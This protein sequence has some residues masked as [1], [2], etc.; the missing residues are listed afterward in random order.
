MTG[1][2]LDFNTAQRQGEARTGSIN[3]DDIRERLHANPRSF[4][5]WLYSGRAYFTKHEARIGN[6]IGE[7]GNSLSIDL[8]TGLWH[9]H[10]TSEGGDLISLYRAWRGYAGDSNFVLSLKEIA[11]DYLGDPVELER[12]TWKPTV[13]AQLAESKAKLGTKPREENVLLGAPVATYTY[14]DT[15]GNVIASVVRFEP[16]GTRASKTFRPWCFKTVDGQPKWSPGAP[17]LRPLYRLPEIAISPTVVLCEGEGCAD[18]LAAIGFPATS[19]MQGAHA[20]IDKTDWSPLAGKT[21]IIWPDN[22][23][24]GFAYAKSVSER[25]LSLGCTVLGITPPADA[26]AKWDAADA[27]AESFDVHAIIAGASPVNAQPRPKIRTF[28]FAALATEEFVEEPDYLGPDFVGPGTFMLIAGPPKAQKSWLVQDINIALATG[29][30]CLGGMMAAPVPLRVFYLQAEMNEKL[31]RRRA[32]APLQWLADDDLALLSTNLIVSDRFRMILDDN[33]V[34]ATIDL[35]RSTFPGAPPDVLTFDPLINLFDQENESDNAQMMKF[36]QL[37]IEAVRDAIN[38][39]AAVIMVHHATKKSADEIRKDPF[40]IIRG[41]GALRGHYDT[42]IVIFKKSEDTEEREVHFDLRAAE[43]PKS[44]TVQLINGAFKHLGTVGSESQNSW[45]PEGIQERILQAIDKAWHQK[46]PWSLS[47][48]TKREGR[49]APKLIQKQFNV[50]PKIA[51]K[52]IEHWLEERV[53][54]VETFNRNTKA[55]GLKRVAEVAEVDEK[56]Q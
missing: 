35:I 4:V 53:L 1:Q 43:S 29:G 56:P 14:F 23:A 10:A 45:P 46:M 47:P 54:E 11:A 40:L 31:L 17:D 12:S 34:A 37:R 41:A 24:P 28:N 48:Q 27:V 21:V 36:L 8:N 30:A 19:A 52:M 13:Q 22:D 26:P 18:R 20:P 5:E 49:Y 16:D 42:G 15:H 32:K 38:P 7:A 3:A 39:R 50:Q 6:T 33:G 9:D 2:I 51:E 25:L 55:R 44:V